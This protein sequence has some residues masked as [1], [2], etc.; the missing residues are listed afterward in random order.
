MIVISDSSPLI[1]LAILDK[2]YLLEKFFKDGYFPNSFYIE[3]TKE[4]KPHSTTLKTFLNDKIKRI[5]NKLAVEVLLSDIGLGEAEAIVLAL[6]LQ[7]AVVLI[8]DL[9][10][11]KFAQFKGLQIIG[12]MGILLQAKKNNIINKVKPLLDELLLNKIRISN[13]IIN[14]TLQTAGELN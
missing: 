4:D 8:D 5:S 13:K 10:A 6:E 9:K 11:R 2:L 1:S 7:P 12:T 3:V 14:I